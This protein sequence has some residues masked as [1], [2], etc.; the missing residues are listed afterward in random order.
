[1]ANV[2]C[3]FCK[4]FIPK[5]SA[6][7]YGLSHFCNSDCL[8]SKRFQK[9]PPQKSVKKNVK[10]KTKAPGLTAETREQVLHRDSY[11][12]RFCGTHQDLCVHHVVYKSDPKN[13]PWENQTS[14]LITLCNQICHLNKVHGNKKKYQKL[15]LQIIWL[16]E[17]MNDKHT[18]IQQLEKQND[19]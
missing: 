7:P 4:T 6:I 12:C 9:P 19:N 18:T 11:R 2:R 13:R 5:E 10:K 3:G 1:M 16:A 8:T 17:V 14:N 15:C